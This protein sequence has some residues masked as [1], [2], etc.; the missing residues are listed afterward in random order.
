MRSAHYKATLMQLTDQGMRA[1]VVTEYEVKSVSQERTFSQDLS[2]LRELKV[3]LWSLS[4]GVAKYLK[5]ADVAAGTIAVKLRH[6]DF[7]TLTRQ[8][9][10]AVP[11]DNERAISPTSCPRSAASRICARLSLRTPH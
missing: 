9:R 5:R 3:K 4:Q 10:L 7:T 1:P 6:A 11:T 2:D 8:M